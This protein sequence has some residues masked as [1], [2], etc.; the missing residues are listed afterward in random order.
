MVNNAS[1]QQEQITSH[2]NQQNRGSRKAFWPGW[3][4]S[5]LLAMF[6]GSGG[7]NMARK[8]SFVLQG[9]AHL[10]F[11]ESALPAVGIIAFLSSL[12]YVVPRTGLLGAVL[13]T[14]YLGG[15]TASH[16]RIGEPIFGPVIFG[17]LV[18]VGLAL[19]DGRFRAL[20]RYQ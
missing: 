2:S 20:I 15:A 13:L 10:G 1:L 12:L 16:V 3:I 5:S 8:A 14:G 7:V 6:I 19:R 11:P 18:W 4:L 9:V 17:I